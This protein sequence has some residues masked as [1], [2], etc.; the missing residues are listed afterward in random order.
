[1][2]NQQSLKMEDMSEAYV[3][4]LCAIN[5]FNVNR[6]TRDNEGWDISISCKGFLGTDSVLSTTK[7]EVQLK[8]TYAKIKRSSDG[9]ISFKLE[10][11]NYNQLIDTK[12]IIPL[13]L[14]VFQMYEDEKKW[15]EQNEEYLKIT[16]CAYWVSLKGEKPTDNKNSI[17]IQIPTNNILTQNTLRDLMYKVSKQEEL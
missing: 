8:A 3:R 2:P 1:M 13:I 6:G 5:G 16:R 10:V 7:I 12:R 14:V 15:L 4:A 9:F 11:K 17:T